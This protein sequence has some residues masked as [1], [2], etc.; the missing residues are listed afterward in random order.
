RAASPA[1]KL[2]N[3]PRTIPHEQGGL[4]WRRRRRG[5]THRGRT[6]TYPKQTIVRRRGKR[7][8]TEAHA[9]P[10]GCT[11]TGV[12]RNGG[13]IHASYRHLEFLLAG[14]LL[15]AHGPGAAAPIAGP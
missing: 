6:L 13:P 1:K 15:S 9:G 11:G 12:A 5:P 8:R 4:T 7:V 2:Q 3:A 10:C 14:S